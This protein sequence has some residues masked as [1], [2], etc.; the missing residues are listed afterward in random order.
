MV[1]VVT[2]VLSLVFA[3]VPNLGVA[4]AANFAIAMCLAIVGP[5]ILASLS[6]VL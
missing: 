2:S 5:G 3:V 4:I 6:L 1:S